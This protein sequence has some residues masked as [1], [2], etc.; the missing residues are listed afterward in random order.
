MDRGKKLDQ[1]NKRRAMDYYRDGVEKQVTGLAGLDGRLNL[2]GAQ[3]VIQDDPAQK[4][5]GSIREISLVI[6]GGAPDS[7]RIKPVDAVSVS[8][9][10]EKAGDG[11]TAAE[12]EAARSVAEKVAGFY[13]L[14]PDQVKVIFK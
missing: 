5:Y 4:D 10:D 7:R 12:K 8:A 11:A 6:A 14:A 1:E 13:N 3:V 9:G 2:S